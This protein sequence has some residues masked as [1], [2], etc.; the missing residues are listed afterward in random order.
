MNEDTFSLVQKLL[1]IT[2]DKSVKISFA[3]SCTGGMIGSAITEIAGA[4]ASFL[5]SAVTY[6]DEAKMSIL[7]VS[8]DTIKQNGAVSAECAEEMANGARRIYNSDIAMS[9]T[10]IAGPNGGTDTKPVGTVWFGFSSCDKTSSF[11]RIFK[12]DRD[13]VREAALK[14]VIFFLLEELE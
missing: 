5:G 1:G 4:S 3:E 10:G 9:V 11:M 2:I 14:Q 6:S 7:G 12:G 8:A 13:K